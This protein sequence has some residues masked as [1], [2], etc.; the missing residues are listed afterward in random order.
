[1]GTACTSRNDPAPSDPSTGNPSGH[2][3]LRDRA[4]RRHAGRDRERAHPGVATHQRDRDPSTLRLACKQPE[5]DPARAD[6]GTRW[7]DDHDPTI[8]RRSQPGDGIGDLV[9]DLEIADTHATR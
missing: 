5:I 3:R 1:V 4:V 7:K 9:V 2:L 6:A 8:P